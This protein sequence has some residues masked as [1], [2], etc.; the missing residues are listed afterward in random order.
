MERM[1][2]SRHVRL[3][4]LLVAIIAVGLALPGTGAADKAKEIRIPFELERGRIYVDAYVDER[5]PF[6]FMVD[7]GASGMGRADVRLVKDLG[8][9]VTGTTT[10]SD[11]INTST[12]STVSIRALRV[13]QLVRHNVEVLSRDYNSPPGGKLLLGLIGPEFFFE[14][15]WTIDYPAREIRLSKDPLSADQP[16][17]TSYEGAFHVPLSI[18]EHDTIGVID[19]G[20]TLQTHFPWS[21][22]GKLG[23]ETLKEAGKGYKANTVL[24]LFKAELPV[25]VTIAGNTMAQVEANFSDRMNRINLGGELYVRNRCVVSIDQKNR[26]IRMRCGG[27]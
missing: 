25:P 12:I 24:T 21:W 7:T 4:L 14:H 27:P 3:S 26:L 6:R 1:R 18:G 11:G 17:V 15:L 22:V 20:S 5:G 13:G 16:N 19:T 23:I 8:L 9:T 2:E 10:N